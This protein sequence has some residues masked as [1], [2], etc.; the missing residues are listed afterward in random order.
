MLSCSGQ[1]GPPDCKAQREW[2]A[3]HLPVSRVR[4]VP[5]TDDPFMVEWHVPMDAS[6]HIK[7]LPCRRWVHHLDC[8]MQYA[9]F[10]V[11][12]A[13][14]KTGWRGAGIDGA[15]WILRAWQAAITR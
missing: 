3:T 6:N 11:G 13:M 14:S 12:C 5:P 7:F 8:A 2:L 4:V 1:D 15:T 9:N 10:G